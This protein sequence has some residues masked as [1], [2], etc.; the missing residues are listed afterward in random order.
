MALILFRSPPG[1]QVLV[2]G[3]G[4]GLRQPGQPEQVLQRGR[5]HGSDPAQLR[6]EPSA[7]DRPEARDAVE[8]AAGHPP[9]AQLAV[10]A[11]REPVRFVAGLLSR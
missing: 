4:D 11:D 5:L 3:M 8:G 6:N 9:T 1:M 7:A 10:K 2:D